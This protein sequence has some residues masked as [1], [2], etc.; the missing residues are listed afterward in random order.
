MKK[1]VQCQLLQKY[2]YPKRPLTLKKIK[3][4]EQLENLFQIE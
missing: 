1:S 4:P 2:Q 3:I